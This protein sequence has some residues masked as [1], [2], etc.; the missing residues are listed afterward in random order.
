M[1]GN[2]YIALVQ[3]LLKSEAP[4]FISHDI[5][6]LYIVSFN[7]LMKGPL[8]LKVIIYIKLMITLKFALEVC[9]GSFLRLRRERAKIRKI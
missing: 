7:F 5:V 3:G 9:E 1:I 4:C 6:K 2:T 8:L